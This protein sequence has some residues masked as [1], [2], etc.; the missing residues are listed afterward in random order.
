MQLIQWRVNAFS[1]S[2]EGGNP[3]VVCVLPHWLDDTILQK[4]AHDNQVSET[5][6][7]V[8][9]SNGFFLRWFSP[10][11]EVDLCGH[12]TLAAAYVLWSCYHYPFASLQFISPQ[13]H[14]QVTKVND[15]ICLR[16][17]AISSHQAHLPENLLVALS[18]APQ[19]IYAG[20][21][22][23][24]LY[25]NAEEI[26]NLVVDYE[27]LKLWPLRGVIVT[28]SAE[29][30]IDFVS[31]FFAPHL[32]I[33]EDPVTG[34][35]HCQLAPFWAQ[36]LHKTQLQAEQLSMRGGR[37]FCEVQVQTV[38]LSGSACLVKRSRLSIQ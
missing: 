30:A 14:L 3:A 7:L 20:T 15:E 33:D 37:I 35:A 5:A 38:L 8:P 27:Q 31:R 1:N 6:F 11:C 28:A 29:M 16:F 10:V 26:K 12:A 23:L 36:R 22:F 34:S 4:I 2:L 21:D 18:L 19:E 24:L 32:G 25:K 9:N 13:H 17:P